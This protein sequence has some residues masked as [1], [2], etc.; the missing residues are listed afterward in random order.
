MGNPDANMNPNDINR[1]KGKKAPTTLGTAFRIMNIPQ[2]INNAK[3][4]VESVTS[5]G[6]NAVQNN[7]YHQKLSEEKDEETEKGTAQ[8]D[9][10]WTRYVPVAAGALLL[11]AAV[12][13]IVKSGDVTKP[14]Q[15]IRDG[16]KRAPAAVVNKFKDKSPVVEEAAKAVEKEVKKSGGKAKVNNSPLARFGLGLM[17]GTGAFMPFLAGSA[18]LS[19]KAKAAPDEKSKEEAERLKDAHDS[20]RPV[21][22]AG[23]KVYNALHKKADYND[24]YEKIALS[25]EAMRR[26]AD[27]R[28]QQFY[29]N[30]KDNIRMYNRNAN[31]IID[32]LENKYDASNPVVQGKI[33]GYKLDMKVNREYELNR[34]RSA[35]YGIENKI[36]KQQNLYQKIADKNKAK[37]K[38]EAYKTLGGK[39]KWNANAIKDDA[40]DYFSKNKK[41]LMVATGVLTAGA[42]INTLHNKLIKPKLNDAVKNGIKKHYDKKIDKLYQQKRE[43]DENTEKKAAA[44]YFDDAMGAVML[45]T[46]KM[47]VELAW[48]AGSELIKQRKRFNKERNKIKNRAYYSR[49]DDNDDRRHNGN[50][51]RGG[52][53]DKDFKHNVQGKGR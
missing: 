45:N 17:Q 25:E 49:K 9:K 15:D 23:I 26:Y 43:E 7:Q 8:K 47:P 27:K 42:A 30:A 1:G 4:N 28:K 52:K 13:R 35:A 53:R 6:L 11:S 36:K 5:S 44:E 3:A 19:H 22:S 46:A 39:L 40:K 20:M 12:P 33:R 37:A 48:T 34:A 32:R 2:T 51:N 38:E 50:N 24:G 29:D 41:K 16:M 18:Y 31:R 10:H 21:A 14:L